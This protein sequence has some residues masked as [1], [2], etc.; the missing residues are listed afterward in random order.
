[1]PPMAKNPKD[2]DSKADPH[3]SVPIVDGDS[4]IE[5]ADY[6]AQY[7]PLPAERGEYVRDTEKVSVDGESAVHVG[8]VR[9][10]GHS[11]PSPQQ[12][13]FTVPANA[14]SGLVKVT[15]SFGFGMSGAALTLTRAP[16]IE[17]FDPLLADPVDWVTLRGANIA[18]AFQQIVDD[19]V[20]THYRRRDGS[21]ESGGGESPPTAAQ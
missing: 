21:G 17:S 1:M 11:S 5:T 13:D 6:Q 4:R 8:A 19:Y 15:N 7:P 20:T 14:T 16:V 2:A 12:L 9:A 10:A 18:E 3:T